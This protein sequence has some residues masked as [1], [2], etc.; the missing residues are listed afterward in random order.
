M[1]VSLQNEMHQAF[2]QETYMYV[3]IYLMA[4]QSQRI[5]PS[6]AGLGDVP[7]IINFTI[8]NSKTLQYTCFDS[9]FSIYDYVQRSS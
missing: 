2:T 4:L 7:I 3:A 1:S 5:T 6:V 8:P 9:Y